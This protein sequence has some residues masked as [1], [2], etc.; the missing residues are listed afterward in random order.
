M[1]GSHLSR[2]ILL[3]VCLLFSHGLCDTTSV[4]KID[5]AVN[6]LIVKGIDTAL[7]PIISDRLRGELVNTGAFRVMERAE[8]Q[9]ILKEQ[10]FQQSG[11]CSD[12][13]CIV[14]VGQL[15]GVRQMVAGTI[16]KIND[17]Y[18][19]TLRMINVETG[20]IQYTV[21]S[22]LS[23]TDMNIVLQAVS[24]VAEKLSNASGYK[25]G[26]VSNGT[27]FLYVNTVPSGMKV[28]IDGNSAPSLS[29]VSLK[30]FPEGEHTIIVENEDLYQD[31][32]ITL[33]A[34][35]IEHLDITP[36]GSNGSLPVFS[37]PPDAIVMLDDILKGRTPVVLNGLSKG[38]HKL[39]LKKADYVNVPQTLQITVGKNKEVHVTMVQAGH[40]S[41]FV[42]PGKAAAI[43]R[44]GKSVANNMPRK[45]PAA[46]SFYICRVSRYDVPAG[47][48]TLSVTSDGYDPVK[49]IFAMPFKGMV[50]K[51][52][53]LVHSAAWNQDSKKQYYQGRWVRRIAFGMIAAA[54]AGGGWALNASIDRDKKTQNAISANYKNATSDFQTYKDSYATIDKRIGTNMVFRNVLYGL[55][56]LFAVGLLI[57]IPF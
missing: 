54:A 7:V 15:L 13:S 40:L 35:G 30:N 25:G 50:N 53:T 4:K 18:T 48:C 47:A 22:D 24:S 20:E 37:D 9:S 14:E 56:G 44:I 43:V 49:D 33:R 36:K 32:T 10:G 16:G 41:V 8:M 6:D 39:L 38:T 34:G 46:D 11:A 21:S 19:I 26:R 42:K 3:S 45:D 28:T 2:G 52:Y 17:L 1:V 12:A 27:G 57:S 23:G 51:E 29:P 55:S 31:T 5:I